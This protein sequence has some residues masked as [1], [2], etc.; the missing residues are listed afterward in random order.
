MTAEPERDKPAASEMPLT[1]GA[2]PPSSEDKW[3]EF[4]SQIIGMTV[5]VANAKHV[6]EHEGRSYYFVSDAHFTQMTERGEFLEWAHVHAHRYGTAK[7]EVM[8]RLDRGEDVIL[9]IDYQ[10]AR[11]IKCAEPYAVT[12]FILPPSSH[13]PQH[14]HT[15]MFGLLAISIARL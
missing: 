12:V 2:T 3:A 15:P 11:Q 13:D 9:D 14:R 1:S 7:A 6:A 5:T 10:G 8:A 4:L